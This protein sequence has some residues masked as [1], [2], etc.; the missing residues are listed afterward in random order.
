M[1]DRIKSLIGEDKLEMLKSVNV[2]LVGLGGVGG[3]TLDALVRSGISNIT[4]VDKDIFEESNLNRQ[5]LCNSLV[6]GEKKVDVAIKYAKLINKDCNIRGLFMK[7]DESNINTLGD[8]DFIIDAIDDVNAK[9]LLMKYAESKN[10]EIISSMGTGKRLDPRSLIITTL[11]KTYNDRL[12]KSVRNKA[13]KSNLS[14]KIPVVS[15][16]ETAINNDVV[17]SS[18]I[19]V[20]SYAGLLL[21][22]FVIEKVIN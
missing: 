7:I 13:R 14:L 17:I 10:I 20:P 9:V 4:V 16:N 8:F 18:S 3:T 11:D 6:L 22:Y 1:F 12:A 5:I 19:F 21:A 2:L 15:A